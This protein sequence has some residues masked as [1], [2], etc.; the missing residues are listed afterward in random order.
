M[1]II[2]AIDII[3]GICVRLE[4][5]DFDKKKEYYKDP[6]DAAKILEGYGFKYLHLVD[7]DGARS[8]KVVNYK[9]LERIAK[10]TNLNIDFGGGIKTDEEV[11]KI[12]DYGAKAISIGSMAVKDKDKF[13]NWHSMYGSEKVY[14]GADCQERMVSISG[15]KEDSMID[16]FEFILDYKAA[17]VENVI[18]TDI[19]RDG[20][21]KGPAFDLYE[22]LIRSTGVNIIASGGVGDI[23]DIVK[24]KELGCSGVVVGKAIYEKRIDLLKLVE[25][26]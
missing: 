4:M 20:M 5:G 15:W 3:N 19:K 1:K 17:G 26:C 22:E 16:I 24:L 11:V 23:S 13:L 8:G 7:L 10:F 12:F 14:L 9:V 25:L 18:C 6:L 2:P 21:L